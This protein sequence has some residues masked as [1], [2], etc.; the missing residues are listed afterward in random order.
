[1]FRQTYQ[2]KPVRVKAVPGPHFSDVLS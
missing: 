1:M 2:A